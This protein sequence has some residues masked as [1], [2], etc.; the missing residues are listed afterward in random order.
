MFRVALRAA[1]LDGTV[2]GEIGEEPQDMF[3]SLGVVMVAAIAFGLGVRSAFDGLPGAAE[4]LE[5]NLRMFVAISTVI[6]SLAI[7]SGL[8]WILG[9][10]LFQGKATYR[11]ILRALGICY[12]PLVVW[13]FLNVPLGGTFV[14]MSSHIWVLMVGVLAVQRAQDIAWWKAG[15]SASMGWL[16]AL[17]IWV[18]LLPPTFSVAPT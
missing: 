15:I 3:R 4:A 12:G 2:F 7:W 18:L 1:F 10:K 5:I 11:A 14:S 8:V 13:L 16:W 17:V 6:T 9:T